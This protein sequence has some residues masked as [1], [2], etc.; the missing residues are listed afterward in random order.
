MS[1]RLHVLSIPHTITNKTFTQCAFTQKVVNMCKMFYNSGMHV[2]HYGHPDSEVICNE[3]V[4]V[5]DRETYTRTYGHMNWKEKG[6]YGYS[7]NDDAY[8]TFSRNSIVEI[9]KR[10]KHGDIVLCF[11]GTGHKAIA[12]SVSD[13]LIVEPCIGYYSGIFAPYRVYESYAMMHKMTGILNG[14]ECKNSFY[15]V[16]IPS[17][18]EVNDFEFRET[19]EDYFLMCGRLVWYKGVH[20]ASQVC[21]ELGKKLVLIGTTTGPEDCY[22]GDNWPDHI[23]YVGFAD[24][25][26]RKHYM[27]RAKALFA[28]TI[29]TEP[30]GNVA[31]EALMSGT[32]VIATD[33]GAFTETVPHGMV[34]YRCRTFEQFIWAAKNIDTIDTKKCR[35]WAL[36]NYSMDKVSSMY[37]EYFNSLINIVNGK[38]WYEPNLSRTNLDWLK[39]SY[40]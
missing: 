38:G 35:Q 40:S 22:L 31:V 9:N 30:F 27:S 37:E 36:D 25:E 34:G 8:T 16:V 2:I 28:P 10:K 7:T 20:I 6:I 33:W 12:D 3:H 29:Y 1:I 5:I 14:T 26:K 17:G 19:K 32:P 23:E 39:K 11:F 18:L 24:I 15:D 13:L 4:D 21:K